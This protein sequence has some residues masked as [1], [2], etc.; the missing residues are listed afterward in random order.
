VRG[1]PD[2]RYLKAF[3]AIGWQGK[4]SRVTPEKVDK[5]WNHDVY[6]ALQLKDRRVVRPF[7]SRLR[8]RLTLYEYF[9]EFVRL[10]HQLLP[11]P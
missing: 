9:A 2:A 5:R 6:V 10:S 4:L 11:S 8:R 7:V 3:F 1:V